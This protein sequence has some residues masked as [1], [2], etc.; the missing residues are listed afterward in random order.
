LTPSVVVKS[1]CF[2]YCYLLMIIV[3]FAYEVVKMALSWFPK[4]KQA[5]IDDKYLIG[6]RLHNFGDARKD[7]VVTESGEETEEIEEI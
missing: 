5:I 1:A 3:C 6:H 4:F 2:R 7:L